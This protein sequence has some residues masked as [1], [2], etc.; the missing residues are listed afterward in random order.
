MAHIEVDLD[1][2]DLGEFTCDVFYIQRHEVVV[3][4]HVYAFLGVKTDL[5]NFLIDSKID[6]I[7][8]TILNNDESEDTDMIFDRAMDR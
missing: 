6:E 3:I 2:G 4:T 1:F 7:K 5:R 8:E